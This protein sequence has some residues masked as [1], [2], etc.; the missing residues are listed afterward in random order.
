MGRFIDVTMPLREG[1][2]EWPGDPEFHRDLA[3][4][5]ERGD[6]SDVAALRLS[7]HTGTHVDAPAHF[8]PGGTT[9]DRIPPDVLV[10]SAR[11]VAIANPSCVDA[12]DLRAVD[13]RPGERLLLRT[14]NSD[15]RLLRGPCDGDFVALTADAARL[16][17]GRG[18]VLVGVDALSV[19]RATDGLE[20]HRVLLGAGVCIVE[21]LDLADVAPGP[22]ALLCLPLRI[23]GGD[24]APARVLLRCG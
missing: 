19:G 2:P 13:P 4:S 10:G 18:V 22:C 5:I 20:T 1:M 17:A 3:L 12:D 7:S 6:P 24:G 14:A 11:V 15:R 16:L 8:L 21:G 9:V 23:E